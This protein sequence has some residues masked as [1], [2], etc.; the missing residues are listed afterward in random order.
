MKSVFICSLVHN[1]ILGGALYVDEQSITYR[2]NKLTVSKELRNLVIPIS[3]IQEITWKWVV[4][5]VVTFHM[6]D[7][8]T[9]KI[10]IFNKWRFE[11]VFRNFK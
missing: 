5:P 8:R 3:E 10:I 9:Y 2:T 11:K 7:Q 6:Q 4:F 1:G